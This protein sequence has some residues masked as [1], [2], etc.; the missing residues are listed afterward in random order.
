MESTVKAIKTEVVPETPSSEIKT[1][2][3]KPDIDSEPFD[4]QVLAQIKNESFIEDEYE[5]FQEIK[6]EPMEIKEEDKDTE[7]FNVEFLADVKAEYAAEENFKTESTPSQITKQE[8]EEDINGNQ[9]VQTSRGLIK[10]RNDLIDTK[11]AATVF[12]I[13]FDTKRILN[14]SIIKQGRQIAVPVR[15]L[16]E[17]STPSNVEVVQFYQ[18]AT[19]SDFK[20]LGQVNRVKEDGKAL[21]QIIVKRPIFDTCQLDNQ[22]RTH[23]KCKCPNTE[24][25]PKGKVVYMEEGCCGSVTLNPG[26]EACLP[27]RVRDETTDQFIDFPWDRR[28]VALMPYLSTP[29]YHVKG[30]KKCRSGWMW[31]KNESTDKIISF[32]NG[33]QIG[34]LCWPNASTRWSSRLPKQPNPTSPILVSGVWENSD[35]QSLSEIMVTFPNNTSRTYRPRLA[36][37]IG[38]HITMCL[39]RFYGTK[40]STYEC[41]DLAFTRA[42]VLNYAF[43]HCQLGSWANKF[44][45][46]AESHVKKMQN[47]PQNVPKFLQAIRPSLQCHHFASYG[48]DFDFKKISATAVTETIVKETP[49]DDIVNE[50][51]ALLEHELEFDLKSPAILDPGETKAIEIVLLSKKPC[52]KRDHWL[53]FDVKIEHLAVVK[54][55]RLVCDKEMTISLQNRSKNIRVALYPSKA[56]GRLKAKPTN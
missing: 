47:H 43:K 27:F 18:T 49:A 50:E 2:D 35:N 33:D 48:K 22:L 11:D 40:K 15:V 12:K 44:Y 30:K 14:K 16:L 20:I 29:S 36:N 34:T 17:D 25:E 41:Y 28:I 42:D 32:S 56:F 3:L 46:L 13:E 31:V 5:S 10:V 55:K 52:L 24:D 8:N 19:D 9:E 53:S 37:Q 21:L 23:V 4:Q 39:E 45:V 51:P 54:G 6:A 1:E 26:A 7:P 38:P